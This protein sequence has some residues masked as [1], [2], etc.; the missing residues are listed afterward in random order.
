[1]RS[2]ENYK[3]IQVSI[4]RHFVSSVWYKC[5]CNN[6]RWP[7]LT[8]RVQRFDQAVLKIECFYLDETIQKRLL[9]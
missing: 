1:M 6:Y 7:T 9:V 3:T 5:I 8:V 2:L 4:T